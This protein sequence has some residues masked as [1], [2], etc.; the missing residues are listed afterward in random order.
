MKETYL[1]SVVYLFSHTYICTCTALWI[2]I[3]H[4]L[5][6]YLVMGIEVASSLSYYR[7]PSLAQKAVAHW[8]PHSHALQEGMLLCSVFDRRRDQRAFSRSH[9]QFRNWGCLFPSHAASCPSFRSGTVKERPFLCLLFRG[10]NYISA[11]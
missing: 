1:K 10:S 6:V 4:T 2:W 7:S 8:S 3:Y 5:S 11:I 9:I